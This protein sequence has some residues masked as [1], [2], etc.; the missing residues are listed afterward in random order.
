M[1]QPVEFFEFPEDLPPDAM[2]EAVEALRKYLVEATADWPQSH[3]SAVSGLDEHGQMFVWGCDPE[4]DDGLTD[5]KTLP[6]EPRQILIEAVR[7]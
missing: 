5:M 7:S 1:D 2:L 6:E 4:F 3:A